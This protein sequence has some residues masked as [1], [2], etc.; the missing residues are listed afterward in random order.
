LE[1][2]KEGLKDVE[3]FLNWLRSF[4]QVKNNK[5][6]WIF[7]SSI[8]IENFLSIHG[9]SNTLNDVDSFEIDELKGDEPKGLLYAL[10]ESKNIIFKD[11]DSSHFLSKLGWALPFYIQVLFSEIYNLKEIEEREINIDLIDDAYQKIIGKQYFN[12]WDERLKE[13]GDLEFFIRLILK[14]LC[15][16]KDGEMRGTLHSILYSETKDSHKADEILSRVLQI[17]INDG[18]AM[19]KEDGKYIFRSPLLRDFW[20]NRFIA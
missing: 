10:G 3:F 19:K 13:Y 17:L 9:L 16:N 18:Y 8:G 14:R 15:H 2:S 1:S 5:I 7:C 6:R 12:T 11:E 20:Y 4:R